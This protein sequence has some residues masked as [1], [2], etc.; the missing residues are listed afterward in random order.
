MFTKD[1]HSNSRAHYTS[2]KFAMGVLEDINTLVLEDIFINTQDIEPLISFP[3]YYPVHSNCLTFKIIL[4]SSI[5]VIM[6]QSIVFNF[7]GIC[8]SGEYIKTIK[9]NSIE[10]ES[11]FVNVLLACKPHR[12]SYYEISTLK[13]RWMEC[14]TYLAHTSH[15]PYKVLDNIHIAYGWLRIEFHFTEL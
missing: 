8:W 6:I 13:S 11:G 15:L 1:I 4:H 3:Y 7:I 2:T 5:C 10:F 12:I 14:C 9:R